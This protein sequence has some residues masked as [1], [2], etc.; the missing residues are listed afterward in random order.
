[1]ATELKVGDRVCKGPTWE[2]GDQGGED[3]KGTVSYVGIFFKHVGYRWTTVVWDNGDRHEYRYGTA[4]QDVI[5]LLE[6]VPDEPQEEGSEDVVVKPS[7]YA[8][9]VIE[10]VTFIMRNGLSFWRGNIIKYA[11]RAGYKLYPGKDERESEITDLK[12]VI[13]YAEMRINQLEGEEVL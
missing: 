5:P 6:V 7:H 3:P 2:W 9:F 1:M 13:R 12:K 4:K 8:R 11:C 10:P